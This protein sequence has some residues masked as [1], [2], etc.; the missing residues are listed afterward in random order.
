MMLVMSGLFVG[1]SQVG[2]RLWQGQRTERFERLLDRFELIARDHTAASSGTGAAPLLDLDA[3][4]DE[5]A[6]TSRSTGRRTRA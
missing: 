2:T 5:A 4:A 1:G 3:E 6:R